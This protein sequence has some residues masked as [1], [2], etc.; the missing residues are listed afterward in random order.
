MYM[1]KREEGIFITFEGGEGSGKT[2]IIEKVCEYLE[3]L[4][5]DYILTREP[6]GTNISEQIRNVI[7]DRKNTEM[8][9][10]TEAYLYAASRNQ[11][12][13]EKVA[14]ALKENKIVM[15]D[16]FVD[17]SVVYQG[18]VRGF[19]M[20]EIFELNRRALYHDNH[21]YTPDLTIY[22]DVDPVIGL[23]RISSNKNREVNRLDLEKMDFHQKVREGYLTWANQN[24]DY[25]KV[26]DASKSIEEVTNDVIQLIDAKLKENLN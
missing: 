12:I 26:V 8:D 20:N 24:P 10:L 23:S 21:L 9:G 18:Y 25:I 19:G 3:S 22:F 2:T 7:L 1:Q 5:E 17:S 15:S 6:G 11:H 14:P 4:G 13:V 16:R